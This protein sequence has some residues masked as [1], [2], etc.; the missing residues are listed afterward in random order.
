MR[1]RDFSIL[2]KDPETKRTKIVDSI[3]GMI[4]PLQRY[5]SIQDT[6]TVPVPYMEPLRGGWSLFTDLGSFSFER[7]LL[8]REA[9]SPAKLDNVKN[10]ETSNPVPS[11]NRQQEDEI[12]RLKKELEEAKATIQRWEVVNN[13][14][15]GK[16]KEC[17]N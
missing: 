12:E 6:M 16:M 17:R 4:A 2:G 9:R 3:A 11:D 15:V 10:V 8:A 14:L 7:A 5:A 13:K 1:E